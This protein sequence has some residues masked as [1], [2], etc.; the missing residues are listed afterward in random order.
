MQATVQG[1][2]LF[3]STSDEPCYV[4][5]GY[6]RED[7]AVEFVGL[8]ES[9]DQGQRWAK[10]EGRYN[11]IRC[12]RYGENCPRQIFSW[13]RGK[14]GLE[15]GNAEQLVRDLG[16]IIMEANFVRTE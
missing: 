10:G 6:I 14:L 4:V 15:H 11:L 2:E 12:F 16:K 3:G 7:R 1:K 13:L 9:V 5:L 8:A